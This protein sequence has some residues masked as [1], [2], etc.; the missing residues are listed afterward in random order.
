MSSSHCN[1]NYFYFITVEAAV[2]PDLCALDETGWVESSDSEEVDLEQD[3][4]DVL[5]SISFHL[6]HLHGHMEV[7]LIN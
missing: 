2:D 5:A 7:H 4:D 3:S 1:N 6:R